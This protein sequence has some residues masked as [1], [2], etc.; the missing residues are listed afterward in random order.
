LAEICERIGADWQE[1]VP[2]LRL[3]RR[4]GPH[5]YL[6][7]GLGIAGG[8]LER[9]LVTVQRLAAENGCDA[10]VVSSW[11]EKSRYDRDWALRVLF[12]AGL[13]RRREEVV[14]GVW[15]LAY[16]PNTQSVKN[17]PSLALLSALPG[18]SFRTYDPVAKM[19]GS[20]ISVSTCGSALEAVQ[21]ASALLVMTPWSEFAAVSPSQIKD[22][23]SGR[24]V[25]DPYRALDGGALRHSGFAYHCLGA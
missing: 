19:E 3:D 6:N 8:N 15:G 16:K 13:L 1:I 24:V 14:F 17:S 11:Q 9:D 25:V 12:R 23:M 18:Y 20:N 22:R 4:I 2:A 5:A 7:P 21:G 10:R